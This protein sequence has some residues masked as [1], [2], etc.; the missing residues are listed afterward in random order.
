MYQFTWAKILTPTIVAVMVC[1]CSS[2]K[3]SS[4]KAPQGSL[5][6]IIQDAPLCDAISA[7][8]TLTGLNFTPVGGGNAAGY[9]TTTPSFAPS[10]RVNLQLLRDFSTPLYIFNVN[11]GNYQQANFS[12]ELAQVATYSPGLTPPVSL[13]TTTLTQ[14]KPTIDLNPHLVIT[15]GQPNVLLLDFDVLH[16][17]QTNSSGQL[18]GAVTPVISATQ[19]LSTNGSP[20]FEIDDLS[21]FVRSNTLIN[22]TSNSLYTG[23]FLMQLLA[24]SVSAAPAISV[25]MSP[26]TNLVGVVDLAHLLPDSYVEVDTTL[27]GQ[28]NFAGNTVEFQAVE[29]PYTSIGSTTPP[30]TALIGPIT[31]ITTDSTGTPTQFNLWVRDAEPQDSSNITLDSIFQVNLTPSTLFQ[32]SVLGP[33]FA[34]LSF[35]PQNLAVG[36]EVVVHG[37]YTKLPAS[38]GSKSGLSV[39][40]SP[41]AIFLKLQ[42]LQGSLGSV[43]SIGSDGLTGAFVLNS[44]CTLLQGAPIYVLTNNQ[45][46]FVNLTG[47]SGLAPQMS[48]LVKGMPF[49]EPQGGVIN[50]I[51]VPAGT[52]VVEAKQVHQL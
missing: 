16:M 37:A 36:Q 26:N 44:C 45:T 8:F 7:T 13:L 11:A 39:T 32:V 35:G 47:L 12:F 20:Y 27:D 40:V 48:L 1:G 17:L 30:H 51:T 43:V 10:I 28:G 18:T 14:P 50:G 52:L 2:T 4:S 23:S 15:A 42:S 34:N 6:T 22:T 21:G 5:I 29:H 49:Y 46:N 31:S 38:T 25:N 24:P 41:S 9:I 33:N 3:S 19:L